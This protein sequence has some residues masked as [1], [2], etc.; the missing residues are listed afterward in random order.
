MFQSS[1]ETPAA[2]AG[3]AFVH[4]ASHRQN[5]MKNGLTGNINFSPS[6][7][8]AETENYLGKPG[9]HSRKADAHDLIPPERC[10]LYGLWPGE[11]EKFRGEN[12]PEKNLKPGGHDWISACAGTTNEKSLQKDP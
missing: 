8:P 7:Q 3:V 11:S 6:L 1:H 5:P 10:D 2:N 12:G 4:A 9:H